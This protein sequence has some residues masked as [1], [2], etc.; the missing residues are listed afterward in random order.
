[1]V[2]IVKENIREM[3]ETLNLDFYETLAK[4]LM[5]VPRTVTLKINKITAEI[6]Y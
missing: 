2:G 4:L 6:S 3:L 5:E 1:M